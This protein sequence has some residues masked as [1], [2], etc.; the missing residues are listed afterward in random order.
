MQNFLFDIFRFFKK[1]STL[2]AVVVV[3]FWLLVGQDKEARGGKTGT[4]AIKKVSKS[5]GWDRTILEL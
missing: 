2:R 1:N 4:N 5:D 3:E